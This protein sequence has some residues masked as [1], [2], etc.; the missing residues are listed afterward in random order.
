MPP[1]ACSTKP[2][3]P[4]VEMVRT[5]SAGNMPQPGGGGD[6]FYDEKNFQLLLAAQLELVAQAMICNA[7]PVIGLM[8]MFAT[9]DFNFSFANAPG[10]HHLGL[11]H[12]NYVANSMAPWGQYNSA[13]DIQN[14]QAS[15]RA[16]FATAQKWFWTQLVN[17]VI[18]KLATTDDPAAPGTK[19]L[20]N[21]LIFWMSEIGDGADHNRVSEVLYPQT[22]DS[23]PLVTIGKA[24]GALKSGQVVQFPLVTDKS[25]SAIVNRPATDLF[26]TLAQAMGA[27]NVTFPGTTGV[28]PGV[29]S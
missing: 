14:L 24:G 26:L 7:A 18:S 3:L 28:I 16:P 5:Q 10:S 11:S 8:P 6:Y 1:S 29:L 19:V 20:D 17:K 25:S 12:S 23:L 4:S 15:A 2:S 22:P 9:C 21:T 13:I 27:K